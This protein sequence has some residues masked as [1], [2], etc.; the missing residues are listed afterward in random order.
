MGHR[1]LCAWGIQTGAFAAY[2]AIFVSQI[3]QPLTFMLGIANSLLPQRLKMRKRDHPKKDDTQRFMCLGHSN[4][5]ICSVWSHFCFSHFS[6]FDF[7]SGECQLLITP[8]AEKKKILFQKG[9][10]HRRFSTCNIQFA[11]NN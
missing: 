9:I 2:G 10:K 6:T 1:G 3:F 5:T 7:H 11:F 8:M 4:W